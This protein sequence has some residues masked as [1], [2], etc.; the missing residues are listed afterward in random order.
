MTEHVL[1]LLTQLLSE[2]G[3]LLS[4]KLSL[5]VVSICCVLGPDG[6]ALSQQPYPVQGSSSLALRLLSL[7]IALY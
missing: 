2:G 7:S 5:C 6:Q 1:D 4:R 3:D